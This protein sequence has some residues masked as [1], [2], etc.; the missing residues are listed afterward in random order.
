MTYFCPKQKKDIKIL[1]DAQ[2]VEDE[3]NLNSKQRDSMENIKTSMKY[4]FE[5]WGW[6][7][8]MYLK[9]V[10]FKMPSWKQI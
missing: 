9:Q 3:L 5:N 4:K 1:F 8:N 2:F 10:D 6:L 7:G